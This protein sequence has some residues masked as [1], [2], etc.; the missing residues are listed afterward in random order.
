MR[1]EK[2]PAERVRGIINVNEGFDR[3]GARLFLGYL[4][5]LLAVLGGMGLS[6]GGLFVDRHEGDTLH[7]IEIVIRM[8]E[9]QWPHLDF[10]TPLGILSFWPIAALVG[11]DFG[12]GSA[13]LWSQIAVAVLLVPMVWWVGVS[14]L[15]RGLAY[16]FGAVVM[17]LVLSLIHGEAEPSISLSMHYN[18]WAWAFAFVGVLTALLKA[19]YRHSDLVDSILIGLAMAFF[20]FGKITYAVALLPCVVI[21]LAYAGRWQVL[22]LSTVPIL[23]V[24]MLITFF[25]G[26]AI[27]AAYLADL[28][29]VASTDVRPRAG[30]DLATLLLS[31]KFA[32][33]TA[34]LVI[35]FLYTRRHLEPQLGMG[36]FLASV[37]GIY[38]TYQ[39]YGNDPKWLALF[40]FL[41]LSMPR[42]RP[43]IALSVIAMTL[44]APSWINMA[45]S[46]VRH[47]LVQDE[48]YEAL[49]EGTKYA[50]AHGDFFTQS[51]RV[52]RVLQRIPVEFSE[53]E[54]SYL[55]D[56]AGHP[57]R[58][59]FQGKE[60]PRCAQQLGLIG[61]TR[62]IAS[63]LD[64]NGLASGKSVFATD[65]FG[66]YWLFG[67]LSPTQ[68]GAPWYY[69]Q[70]SGYE[71]ADYVL[72][73]LCPNTPSVWR[74]TMTE[75]EELAEQLELV[76]ETE[77]YRLYAKP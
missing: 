30:V 69:G 40:A 25:A 47:F 18:R 34:I 73:P 55:N 36:L 26:P 56:K 20:L 21:A 67:G 59:E 22:L 11:A 52:N 51:D 75:I 64:R 60:L 41:L 61:V 4:L 31:P 50:G 44:I 23:A 5:G 6:K 35:G 16:G 33:G 12:V 74:S 49:F 66:N 1:N 48:R 17:I 46:P 27:W 13:I 77:L 65:T 68:G 76:R 53:A 8:S 42:S 10:V 32:I 62:A 57:P 54:F 2:P 38:I 29:L 71:A 14:R 63:D 72:V 39:N 7:L 45:V 15:S 19:K 37:G 28:K 58:A 3:A 43:T 24:A 9:G 70:L